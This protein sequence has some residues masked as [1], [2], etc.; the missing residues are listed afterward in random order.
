MIDWRVDPSRDLAPWRQV[1]EA[2]LDAVATGNLA[3]NVQLLSVRAMASAAQVNHN[4]VARAYRELEQLGVVRGEN[5]RGVF[6][7]PDGPKIA[8]DLRAAA[9]LEAFQQ[10]ALDALRAGHPLDRLM[11]TL[12][13]ERRNSA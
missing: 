13:R 6:V 5:G 1:I 2:V 12:E 7:Q 8:L 10:A 9:T 4:T 3:A 11:Q